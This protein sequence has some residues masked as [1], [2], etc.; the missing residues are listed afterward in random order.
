M[1]KC[2]MSMQPLLWP[3]KPLPLIPYRGL[4]ASN[5]FQLTGLVDFLLFGEEEVK[6]PAKL[7]FLNLLT[8]ALSLSFDGNN[9]GK[10]ASERTPFRSGMAEMLSL[11]NSCS[12]ESSR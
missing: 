9:F 1:M 4:I 7:T 10:L 2:L 12:V 5:P 11:T 8:P 6:N 3:V